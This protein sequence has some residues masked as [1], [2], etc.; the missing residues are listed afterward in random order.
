MSEWFDRN[1][2]VLSFLVGTAFFV[3]WLWTRDVSA[4]GAS[5]LF[6]IVGFL[7]DR[8]KKAPG[9]WKFYRARFVR[10]AR[11][12]RPPPVSGTGAWEQAPASV[13]GTGTVFPRTADDSLD[14]I[15]EGVDAPVSRHIEAHA[16]AALG[17]GLT[18]DAVIAAANAMDTANSP[19][20]LAER[21]IEYVE[22][23]TVPGPRDLSDDRIS[24]EQD[25]FGAILELQ[26]LRAKGIQPEDR[27]SL[28]SVLERIELFWS[29]PEQLADE[30]VRHLTLEIRLLVQDLGGT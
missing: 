21:T 13:E 17:V 15:S 3:A 16:E 29:H 14:E 10:T 8:L 12:E 27:L 24:H 30:E 25:L 4:I 23:R 9:G 22:L 18:L 7:G 1:R 6:L 26:S 20:E 5:L 11:A 28:T 19:E 2:S